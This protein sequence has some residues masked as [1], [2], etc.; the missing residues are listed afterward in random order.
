MTI[1][2]V[3]FDV[4]PH[5]LNFFELDNLI[6]KYSITIEEQTPF[7]KSD[8]GEYFAVGKSGDVVSFILAVTEGREADRILYLAHIIKG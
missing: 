1:Y 8:V 4:D 7:A 6:Q 5:S 2:K 3:P